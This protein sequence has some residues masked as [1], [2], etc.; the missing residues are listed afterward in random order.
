MVSRLVMVSGSL[1]GGKGRAVPCADTVTL[2]GCI[3]SSIAI[4]L[5]SHQPAY[6]RLRRVA[7]RDS[8]YRSG[9]DSPTNAATPP[10]HTNRTTQAR[11][12]HETPLSRAVHQ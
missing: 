1:V 9:A 5:S 3:A 12:H 10:C 8:W 7:S 11:L 2:K 6:A 4:Y